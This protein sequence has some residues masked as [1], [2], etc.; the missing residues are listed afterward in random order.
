MQASWTLQEWQAHGRSILNSLMSSAELGQN[1][2]AAQ[3][4]LDL[5]IEDLHAGRPRSGAPVP[6]P[7]QMRL[8][9]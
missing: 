1:L 3:N 6:D 5:L 9:D 8:H 7:R 2:T 4:K